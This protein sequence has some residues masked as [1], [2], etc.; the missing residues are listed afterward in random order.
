MPPMMRRQPYWYERWYG[1]IMLVFESAF[2]KPH[3]AN[4]FILPSFANPVY[5]PD[6]V[7]L[8]EASGLA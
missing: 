6:C 4:L 8:T 2:R 5:G 7:H 1:S 3:V